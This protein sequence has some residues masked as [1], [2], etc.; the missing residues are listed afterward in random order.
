MPQI[1]SIFTGLSEI[2]PYLITVIPL[3]IGGA[4]STLNNVE[5]AAAAGDN[6]NVREAMIVDGI[7]SLIGA[8]FGNP[9]ATGTYIGHPGWKLI[10]ARSGYCI[11]T[12]VATALVCFTTFIP[13]LMNLV[14]M[15][16]LIP[17]LIYIA[18]V[19]GAQAFQETPLKHAPAI[20]LAIIPWLAD[21]VVTNIDNTLKVVGTNA[22]AA[23]MIDKL[24]STDILYVA[25]IRLSYGCVITSM[26]LAM[27][28][29]FVIDGK[30]IKATYITLA[31]AA[32]SFFCFIHA[33][34]IGI[35]MA[36]DAAIGYIIMAAVMALT[37]FYNLNFSSTIKM[38]EEVYE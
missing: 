34:N 12:G 7:G 22:L 14:P 11:E 35:A 30:L 15:S 36:V 29:V 19:M 28:A 6:Y 4:L 16:A 32:L 38:K 23:G 37:H 31:A 18:L 24:Y 27:L 3:G 9:F 10:G 8:I 20:V 33:P 5:S 13:V 25:L 2:G 1:G 17:I 21:W 26:L